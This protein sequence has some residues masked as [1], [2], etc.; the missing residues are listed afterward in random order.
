MYTS[1]MLTVSNNQTNCKR[2]SNSFRP[3]RIKFF[4]GRFLSIDLLQHTKNKGPT[5]TGEPLLQYYLCNILITIED[6]KRSML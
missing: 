4:I 6:Q 1:I 3:V 2:L 5:V